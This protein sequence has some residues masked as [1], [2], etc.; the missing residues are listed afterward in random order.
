MTG[1]S[2]PDG[3]RRRSDLAPLVARWAGFA[4]APP[5]C[6]QYSGR[7]RLLLRRGGPAAIL[8]QLSEDLSV[9]DKF[10]QVIEKGFDAAVQHLSSP[11]MALPSLG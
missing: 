10:E 3:K 1:P 6:R 5:A 9:L 11:M 7:A 8:R 2:L 4:A